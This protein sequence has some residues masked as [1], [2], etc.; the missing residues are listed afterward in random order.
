MVSN[1]PV[2]PS[3]RTLMQISS[4]N[5]QGRL[6]THDTERTGVRMPSLSIFA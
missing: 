4:P 6:Y 2:N 1:A 5:V 3:A